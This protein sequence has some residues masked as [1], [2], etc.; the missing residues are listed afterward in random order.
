[1]LGGNVNLTNS[2]DDSGVLV[3]VIGSVR[4]AVT[5]VSGNYAN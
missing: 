1:M 5:D 4:S 3:T 2:G